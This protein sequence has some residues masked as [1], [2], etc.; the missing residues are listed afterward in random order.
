[1]RLSVAGESPRSAACRHSSRLDGRDN[2]CRERGGSGTRIG[3]QRR[4]RRPA[5][6]GLVGKGLEFA[7]L[8][9]LVTVLPRVLGP[10]DYGI[11][12]LGASLVTIAGGAASLGGPTLATRFVAA[13]LPSDRAPL[14]R[15]VIR[16]SATWRIGAAAL[17]AAVALVARPADLPAGAAWLI[18]AAVALDVVA[19]LLLQAALPLGGVLAWS[20]RYPFQNVV[21]TI[22][23][24]LLHERLGTIGVVAALPVA[25][26]AALILGAVTAWPRLRGAATAPRLRRECVDSRSS[27]ARAG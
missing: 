11:F 7:S 2:E 23:A 15:A 12:A 26:G 9:P 18:F 19:T 21:V 5:T 20:L 16:R 4:A 10:S 6:I 22:A 8:I 27:R 25:S 3:S 14:A 24:L 13:A 1:M 17:V